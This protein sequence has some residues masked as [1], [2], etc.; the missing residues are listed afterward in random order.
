LNFPS[1]PWHYGSTNCASVNNEPNALEGLQNNGRPNRTDGEYCW[2]VD[3]ETNGR[4]LTLRG[5]ILRDDRSKNRMH[6]E[7]WSRFFLVAPI[8]TLPRLSVTDLDHC[9]GHGRDGRFHFISQ[10]NNLCDFSW[11]RKQIQDL[12]R[13]SKNM[14]KC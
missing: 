9:E 10:H 3:K 12:S 5:S 6:S 13:T 2:K 14:N 1:G 11:R 4:S 8:T 7:F